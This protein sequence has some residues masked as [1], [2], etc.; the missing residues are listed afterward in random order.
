MIGCIDMTD[1]EQLADEMASVTS[2]IEPS[3]TSTL[4][5]TFGD[6]L[7][8]P[9]TMGYL[10]YDFLDT[11]NRQEK[12][13]DKIRLM[14]LIERGYANKESL[15]KIGNIVISRYLSRLSDEQRRQVYKNIIGEQI[16]KIASNTIVLGQMNSALISKFVARLFFSISFSTILTIGA[17]QSKAVYT[18]R[19]LMDED[20]VLYWKLRSAGDLDLLYFLVE[21]YTKPFEKAVLLK[22]KDEGAFNELLELY[23]IK[24]AK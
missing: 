14:Y 22:N 7:S 10:A 15:Y 21:E 2:G 24:L 16:G 1:L 3:I 5:S 19:R 20:P 9:K 18:S 8:M 17:E 6:L 13:N 23:L 11:G 12:D 4:S